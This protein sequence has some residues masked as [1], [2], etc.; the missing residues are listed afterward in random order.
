M[1]VPDE[2]ALPKQVADL[3][4]AV[5]RPLICF[6]TREEWP[7][8]LYGGTCFI[9]RFDAGLIGVTANHV[10]EAFFR[11]AH[12]Q[13]GQFVYLLRTVQID[14]M[15]AII[16][17]NHERDIAT[18]RVAEDQ[19]IGSE[20]IA[21]D[22]RMEW[23]PPQPYKGAALSLAGYPEKLKKP[24]LHSNVE[25]RAYVNMCFAESVSDNDILVTY[26]PGRDFRVRAAAEFPDLGANLSGCSGGPVLMHF[27][28]NG[29]HRWFPV[30]VIIA[31][32]GEDREGVM[33]D[34][35]LIRIRRVNAV[36]LDGT[37]IPVRETFL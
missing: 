2:M 24:S 36:R 31:G 6:N 27:E 26:E 14:L 22:C 10:I 4:M 20:A 18:F 13:E 21:I 9:L 12:G 7:K 16:D 11:K 33:A 29:Y 25:F 30:G 3:T 32:S 23:P 35:E 8:R 28:R 17:R 5:A 1:Q 19:L 15:A 37:I 34:F